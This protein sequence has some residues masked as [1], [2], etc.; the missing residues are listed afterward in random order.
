MS[1]PEI[2]M[3]GSEN[4]EREQGSAEHNE[5]GDGDS[6]TPPEPWSPPAWSPPEWRGS[7]TGPWRTLLVAG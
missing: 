3:D 6:W 5:A 1:T 4:P 7:G 2:T